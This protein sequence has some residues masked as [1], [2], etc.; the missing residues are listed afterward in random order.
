MPLSI[1]RSLTPQVSGAKT[2]AKMTLQAHPIRRIFARFFPRRYAASQAD[3]KP[4]W[5]T[6][7]PT[8]KKES[9]LH[10][11]SQGE[12]SLLHGNLSALP[13]FEAASQLDPE[14]PQIWYRQGLSFFEY[15]SEEGKEK[16][17]LLAS[18]HFKIATQIDPSFFDAYVAW[19]NTLLQL[20]RFHAE[21]HFLIEAKEKYQKAMELSVG[22]PKETLAELNWDCGIVWLEIAGHSGEALDLS[23]AIE[24]FQKAKEIFSPPELLN[25]CG[26]AYLEMGLLINDPRL[27]LQAIEYLQQSVQSSPQYFDGWIALAETYSQL[28][29][30]T[31]DER[32]VGRASDAFAEAIKLSPQDADAW[33]SWAQILGESGRLSGDAKAIRLS[34]E[35]CARASALDPKNP[36]SIAQWVESLSY[37]GAI[38]SRLDLLI[39]AESK[40]LK[41]TDAFPDD[42]D[43]WLAYGICL[44]AFGRYYDDPEYYEMAIEKLQWGLSIDR[45]SAEHWYALGSAHSLYADLL[46]DPELLKRSCRFFNRAIDL[47]PS[48][49]ALI[50]DTACTYLHLS[51]ITEDLPTLEIAIS[52]FESLLQGYQE[53]ILHHPEWLFQYA[54]ALEWLGDFSGEETHYT[55]AIEIFSHVLLIHPD[56]PRI[57][58]H[59]AVCYLELGHLTFELEFYKKAIH[60]FRLAS[61]SD[62]ENDQI[63]L[64]WGICLIYL[65][66]HTLDPDF[67]HQLYWDAEQ[68]INRAGRL[69]NSFAH[70]NLACL[71]S[72]LGHTDEAM[73]FIEKALAAK[74]LPTLD[75]MADD[76]WLEPLRATDAFSQFFSSLEARLHQ[77]REE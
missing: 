61:R 63:W 58:G 75:E 10:Y 25:D 32:Y 47:K 24:S 39:E 30:N 44:I 76:E 57:H 21:H 74:A 19:G 45:T 68:K 11:L 51:R 18:K 50:F 77:T 67:R 53:S 15:G 40:I 36:L 66:N 1:I 23:L 31:M 22:Q 37:L 56:F 16:S 41:A 6:L 71:Y 59:L 42:P 33:L 62:E 34:I 2:R 8:Q 27:Y 54:Y 69:G 29:I 60:F 13:L 12:L 28:Y 43:L 64:D 14:N 48:Y 46:E 65:A 70:Y 9:A 17:L 73:T 20:G 4:Q 26:K 7:P 49:P 5:D 52:H 72:I 3:P 35:K 55:R 38:T